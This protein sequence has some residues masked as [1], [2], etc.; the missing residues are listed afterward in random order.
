LGAAAIAGVSAAGNIMLIVFALTQVLGVGTVGLISHAVGRKD[1]ADATRVFNQSFSLSM[2]CGFL[3]LIVGYLI[4]VPYMHALGA[5]AATVSAGID[6]LWWF[7]PSLALQFAV[8][9]MGSALRGTGIVQPSMIVQVLTVILNAVLAPVLIAGWGTG[10]PLGVAGAGLASSLSLAV[11]V[12]LLAVYFHRLEHYV[13]FDS[14]AWRWD[15]AVWGR[16]LRIGLPAGGEFALMF[17]YMMIIYWLIRP[18]GQDAQAGF[19]IGMRLNQS[20]FLPAMAV[21]F[22]T[23]PIV[24]QNYAAGKFARVRETFVHA[25]LIGAVIMVALTL[26]CQW[27]A[28]WLARAFTTEPGAVAVATQFLRLI[29]L[30]FIASGLVFTCSAV[31]QGLGNTV[32]AMLSAATRLVSFIVPAMWLAHQPHFRLVELWY[33]SIASMAVQAVVSLWLVRSQLRRRMPDAVPAIEVG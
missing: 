2:V 6:Y 33:V 28:E 1:Q 4:A 30:N 13:T 12:V 8:V 15:V 27:R 5:D 29:S 19:G 20:L 31:F 24:G 7:L 14:T 3:T 25:T 32:P 16:L 9:A 18:F 10:H 17:L 26:L 23:A 11:G 22:A 21:A